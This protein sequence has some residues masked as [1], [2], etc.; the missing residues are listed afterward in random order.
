[1]LSLSSSITQ[2]FQR[3]SIAH[4]TAPM[5]SSPPTLKHV[6]NISLLPGTPLNAGLTPRGKSNWVELLSGTVTTP[7]G[8]QI[9]TV[10]S[11]GGDYCRRHVSDLVLEVDVRVLAK[12]ETAD[13]LFKFES[14]GFDKLIPPVMSVLDGEEP[15][16][17]PPGAEMPKALFGTEVIS[18]DTSSKEFWWLN[19]AVLVAKVALVLG[20]KGVE[21]VDYEIYQVLV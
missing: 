6:L 4:P 17:P 3:N 1:M 16:P 5:S 7:S 12:S 21:R 18:V 2:L 13:A 14:R 10:L 11:G 19:F 8:R 20:E 9:A 15:K